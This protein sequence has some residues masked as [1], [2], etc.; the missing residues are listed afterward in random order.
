MSD[1]FAT[2]GYYEFTSDYG[3]PFI[4]HTLTISKIPTDRFSSILDRILLGANVTSSSGGSST[5][6]DLHDNATNK[7]NAKVLRQLRANITYTIIMPMPVSEAECG[8]LSGT[9]SGDQASFDL[10][11]VLDQSKPIVV[12]S[13]EAN[14]GYITVIAGVVIII[15]LA[16]SFMGSKAIKRKG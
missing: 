12:K 1:Y 15:A 13:N 10:V 16:M 7:G 9:V 5:A 6:I 11:D 3:L 8:N 2:G 14:L 4:T